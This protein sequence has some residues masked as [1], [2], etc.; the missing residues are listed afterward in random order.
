M[1]TQPLLQKIL[2]YLRPI[3]DII[4]FTNKLS[5]QLETLSNCGNFFVITIYSNNNVPILDYKDNNKCNK[6]N[7][8]IINQ[9]V[10]WEISK[11]FYLKSVY[12]MILT[13]I[14]SIVI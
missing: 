4:I 3:H 9:T 13:K 8:A 14:P 1:L 10:H 7:N 6:S 2:K 11:Y 12:Y 5:L